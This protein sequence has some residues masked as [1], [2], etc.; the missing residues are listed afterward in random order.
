MR[1]P[2]GGIVAQA[3]IAHHGDAAATGEVVAEISETGGGS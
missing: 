2:I 3:D 1:A